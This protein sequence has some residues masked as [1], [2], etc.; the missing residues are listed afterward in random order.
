MSAS[1]LMKV[2][3]SAELA[4]Q[5]P[6]DVLYQLEAAGQL[7][8]EI[9]DE[10]VIQWT[11]ESW[12]QRKIADELGCSQPAVS[13]RQRR[14][15]IEPAQPHKAPAIS[16]NRVITSDDEPEI[17]DAEPVSDDPGPSTLGPDPGPR[18]K[19]PACGHMVKPDDIHTWR[20]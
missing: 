6:S 15:G 18:V 8:T 4:R 13:K 9:L 7:A 5:L 17:V 10:R 12:S 16:D 20:E 14:L 11:G 19:C 2:P 3:E 1:E